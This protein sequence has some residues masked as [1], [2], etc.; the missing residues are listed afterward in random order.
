MS[1]GVFYVGMDLGTF[2][3]SVTASNGKRET[4]HTA[5]GWPKDHVAR[6]MLGRDMLFGE[7]ILEHRLALDI[8]RPFAKGA[9]K[10]VDQGDAAISNEDVQRRKEAARMLVRHAVSAM[11]PPEGA[12]V[13]GVIGAPSRAS[14]TG[15]QI[16]MEAV[17]EAF[18]A[19][20][21]V[22]EP[23]TVA[24]SMDRL[25]DTLVV[26]IGAGT[27]DIC[28]MYGT[29]PREE[30]QVTLPIGGDAVDEEFLQ[31][32]RQLHPEV[33]LSL[34]MAR[35][36]KEKYGFVH[37]VNETAVVALPVGGKPTEFDVTEPLKEACRTLV[38]PIIEAIR[39]VIARFDPEFQRPMLDN[40]LL[41]GGGS[42]LKGLDQL[43]E[44]ALQPYGG[45][46]VTKVYD[47]VFAGASGA[48]KL[49]MSMPADYWSKL[50]ESAPETSASPRSSAAAA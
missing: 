11:Q 29:Y 37:D 48:L 19:V 24:Y 44:K 4:F 14:V 35:K 39:E 22:A 21:V 33:Q 10:Y 6:A 34:N 46:R 17:E 25:S 16:L 12:K 47:S 2:K 26:D 27:I 31:R 38:S 7:E 13:Y 15:K 42:G 18:D 40:I 8:V 41:G 5:V 9:L 1:D 20:V 36:I 49:A 30:D 50:S 43:V 32:L 28:P 23:F 3:T 45:G